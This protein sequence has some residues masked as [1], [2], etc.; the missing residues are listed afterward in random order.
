MNILYRSVI[1][2][3]CDEVFGVLVGRIGSCGMV[4]QIPG[5]IGYVE[6][7]YVMQNKMTSAEIKN[8]SGVFVD[9]SLKSISAAAAVKLPADLRVS[10]TNTD[11]KDGY[12]IS[13]FTYII[14]YVNQSSES[15]SQAKA[16][17]TVSL[18]QWMI[19][20]GQRFA[21]PLLYAPLPKEAASAALGQL[22]KVNFAG[23]SLL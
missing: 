13:S 8:K 3:G 1:Q 23:K 16:K 21:A 5:S 20:N 22:K 4:K 6:L 17:A 9:A 12:P 11:A 19:T 18:I 10:L 15:H 7:A 14:L 2:T